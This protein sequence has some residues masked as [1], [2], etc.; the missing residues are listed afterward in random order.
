MNSSVS[1]KSGRLAVSLLA[2]SLCFGSVP[3]FAQ[4]GSP[5]V[6]SAVLAV[7]AFS[8]EIGL[9]D[10]ERQELLQSSRAVFRFNGY[11]RT[12]FGP[13]MYASF[14][15]V[16]LDAFSAAFDPASTRSELNAAADRL[17]SFPPYD[18]YWDYGDM[19]ADQ[20]LFDA[21]LQLHLYTEFG[22][23]PGQW[24]E[25]DA[26]Q[27]M[28]EIALIRDGLYPF[29]T[30]T[31]GDPEVWRLFMDYL[32]LSADFEDRRSGRKAVFEQTFMYRTDVLNRIAA[33]SLP[34][35][36]A[37]PFDNA[38]LQLEST[39]VSFGGQDDVASTFARVK[40]AYE[41]LPSSGDSQAGLTADIE[42]AR[43]LL[44]LPKGIRS[45]QYPASAF[46][47]LRRAINEANLTLKRGGTSSEL[48]QA[49][50]K[51][52]AAIAEFHGRKKP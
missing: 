8:P 49:R 2:A 25:S 17:E 40:S 43:K 38:V 35:A 37:I 10:A 3:A 4:N 29:L 47:N 5:S 14:K 52:A 16:G 39:L 36:Q 27:F 15:Q 33:G 45:G 30:E 19:G 28:R 34:Q 22:N 9:Q 18:R 24:N 48:A 21:E 13:E 50:S 6:F 41:A 51:L 20:I 46:G 7:G 12:S 26:D 44:D 23:E 1:K 32:K 11:Y 31:G 42:E